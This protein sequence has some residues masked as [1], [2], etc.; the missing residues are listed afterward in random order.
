MNLQADEQEDCSTGMLSGGRNCALELHPRH[1][2]RIASAVS[3]LNAH[4]ADSALQEA[5]QADAVPS[6]PHPAAVPALAVR[7]SAGKES[8]ESLR[9]LKIRHRHLTDYSLPAHLA[10]GLMI[11]H[12][13]AL[14]WHRG[15]AARYRAFVH[16]GSPNPSGTEPCRLEPCARKLFRKYGGCRCEGLSDHLVAESCLDGGIV[17]SDEV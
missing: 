11:G 8:S 3:C 14:R 7:R 4:I 15:H 17:S 5:L 13:A 9:T 6:Q 1:A 2:N 16:S 10:A 12:T